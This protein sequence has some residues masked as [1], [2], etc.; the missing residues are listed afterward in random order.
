MKNNIDFKNLRTIEDVRNARTRI[1]MELF[2]AERKLEDNYEDLREMVTIDYWIER[3]TARVPSFIPIIQ[4]VS[5]GY[6][7]ISS[8][9]RRFC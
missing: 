9:I 4:S 2:Y 3:L 7:F 6:A 5:S 1:D 8:L